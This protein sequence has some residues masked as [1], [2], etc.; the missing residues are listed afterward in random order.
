VPDGTRLVVPGDFHGAYINVE[1][2]RRHTTDTP[3][4]PQHTLYVVGGS[5]IYGAEVP[6]AYT[7]PSYLQR[8]LNA[9]QPGIWRLENCGSVSVTTA[10]Q[11][12]L[13]RT[14]PLR[15]GDLVVFYDG[16]NDVVQGVYNGDPAGWMVGENRKTLRAAGPF[17]ALLAQLNLKYAASKALSYSVFLSAVVGGAANGANLRPR[18]HLLDAARTA[19]LAR[20]TASLFQHNLEKAARFAVASGCAFVHFLQPQIFAGDR[21]TPYEQSLIRNYYINP[22]GLETAF[23]A[24]WPLLEDAASRMEGGH[25]YDLSHILDA[26]AERE[27]FYLDYCH[28]NHAANARIATAILEGLLADIERDRPKDAAGYQGQGRR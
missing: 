13:L 10:Q 20:Q 24:A 18:A 12:E 8:L 26:R 27:E 21:R 15:E 4:T 9:R 23:Q 16:V 17:K 3:A 7:I 25:A 5:A 28:V 6:D 14:L 11:L 2:G 19:A 1:H 22:N